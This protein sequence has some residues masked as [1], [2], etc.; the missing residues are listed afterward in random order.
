MYIGKNSEDFEEQE[1]NNNNK[2]Y[3]TASSGNAKSSPA[4]RINK[5]VGRM[6]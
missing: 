5:V 6:L 4:G 1:N 3:V 2:N